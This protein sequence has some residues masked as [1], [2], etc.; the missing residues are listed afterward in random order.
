MRARPGGQR[1]RTSTRRHG[2]RLRIWR[3]T[4]RARASRYYKSEYASWSRDGV[5]RRV[6]A[7]VTRAE[8]TTAG[9]NLSVSCFE[10]D[11]F[12]AWDGVGLFQKSA[13]RPTRIADRV[14]A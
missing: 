9:L 3:G 2:R 4:G 5:T 6:L 1:S 14:L 13:V 7:L 10:L 8:V 12:L 11:R